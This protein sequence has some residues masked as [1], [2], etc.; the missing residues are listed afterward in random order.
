VRERDPAAA[1]DAMR[2]HL[3]TVEGYLRE[4]ARKVARA[5]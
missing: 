5:A 4:H 2:A 3:D 1:R